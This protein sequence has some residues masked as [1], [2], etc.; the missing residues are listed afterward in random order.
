MFGRKGLFQPSRR[1]LGSSFFGLIRSSGPAAFPLIR[2]SSSPSLSGLVMAPS[3]GSSGDLKPV[4][5][6]VYGRLKEEL[7]HD[8]AFDYTEDARRWIEKV[9]KS[10]RNALSLS[11]LNF[12]RSRATR[13]R[14]S[15]L[16]AKSASGV[17]PFAR[18]FFIHDSHLFSTIWFSI[19]RKKIS[20][21]I[22]DL[23]IFLGDFL[24]P[25]LLI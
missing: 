24:A 17:D 6:E 19:M 13:R 11:Q 22:W 3:N 18:F 20:S 10:R 1:I 15:E 16:L 5:G 25:V 21:F 23:R 4:F 9:R 7:L 8:P 2:V 14:T 12:I